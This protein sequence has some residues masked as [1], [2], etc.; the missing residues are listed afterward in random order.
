MN[1]S[2][3][4]YLLNQPEEINDIQTVALEKVLDEFPYFQSAR[5]LRLKG[6]YNQNSYKYNFALKTTAAHTTD[7]SV[8][9]DF[10]TSDSFVAIQKK[11]YEKKI[12]ELLN[13]IVIDSEIVKKEETAPIATTALEQSILTSIK[14]ASSNTDSL[15]PITFEKLDINKNV[16]QS[17]LDSIKEA[18]PAESETQTTEAEKKLEIGKPLDFSKSETH[19]FHQWLQLSRI[20]PIIRENNQQNN[21][22]LQ[23]PEPI[24]DESKI[25]KA[26]LIDKFIETSPKIPPIKP[27]TVFSPNIDLNKE[28]NSYLMTETL[29]KVYLEQKKYQKAIQAYEILILKYPEKSSLFADRIKDIK[30]VQQNNN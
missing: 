4:N 30:I 24:V 10:I 12:E 26:A 23:E 27:G 13:I 3:Y 22:M 14:E 1:V 29:A 19:S 16:E 2:S 18:S 8:L 9:F 7:R 5:A 6:L 25:K 15:H 21:S 17:I 28:D 20:E 11:T